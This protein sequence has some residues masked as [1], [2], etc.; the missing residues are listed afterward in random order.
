MAQL[1]YKELFV[2][3]DSAV[4]YKN[5]KVIP[6]R[7]KSAGSAGTPILSFGNAFRTRKITVSERGTASTENVH[8][9][10]VNNNSGQPVFIASGEVVLGGRQDRMVTKDTILQ[11]LKED[12]YIPVMCVE[13]GRWSDKEKK[14]VYASFANPKLRKVLDQSKNQILVW[15]EIY[16]QLDSSNINSPTLAYAAK[17][18]DKK[19]ILF[20]DEYQ[21]YIGGRLNASDTAIVGFVCMTGDKIIGSDIFDDPAL[22]KDQFESLL[23]GYIEQAINYGSPNRVTNEAVKIYLD[24]FLKDQESQET[25]L[26]KNGKIF[27]NNGKAFHITSY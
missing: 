17:K 22:L 9:L 19:H 24:Q 11:S 21:R 10:R 6:I 20:S 3:Y 1:T 16:A 2:D 18:I 8:W 23:S 14:F 12:Q 27:R 7:K 5:L 25:F 15:K 4:E 26:R 13:E